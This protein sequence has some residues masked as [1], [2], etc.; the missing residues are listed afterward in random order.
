MREVYEE[1]QTPYKYGIVMRGDSGKAVDCPSVFR[2]GERWYMVYIC[3]NEVG[4]ETHLAC[5]DDL[6]AWKTLG[7]ILPFRP[8]AWDQWQAAGVV[9]AI[10]RNGSQQLGCLMASTGCLRGWGEARL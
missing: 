4:Y 3:M 5:S 6:L 7:K 2:Y 10:H 8:N 9:S 1:V